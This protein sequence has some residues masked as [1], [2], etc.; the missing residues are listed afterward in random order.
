VL[1]IGFVILLCIFF[2][3]KTEFS[4][5]AIH[6]NKENI[7][8]VITIGN[9][10]YSRDITPFTPAP[11]G[12]ALKD[13][14]PQIKE[15]TN[16]SLIQKELMYTQNYKGVFQRAICDPSFVKIFTFKLLL[17][18]I[19]SFSTSDKRIIFITNHTRLQLFGQD[20]PIGKQ[21]HSGYGHDYTV[22][23]V[24]DD[25]PKESHIQ[26]DAITPMISNFNSWITA[27]NQQT[28]ILLNKNKTFSSSELTHLKH[29][30]KDHMKNYP[31]LKFQPLK[32]I[33]FNNSF[34]DPWIKNK[35]DKR[36]NLLLITATIILVFVMLFNYF[37][38][39]NSLYLS[40]LKEF[41]I[42][43]ILGLTSDKILFEYVFTNSL[44]IIICISTSILTF[45]TISKFWSNTLGFNLGGQLNLIIIISIVFFLVVL[46]PVFLTHLLGRIKISSFSLSSMVNSGINQKSRIV[47]IALQVAI[48]IIIIIFA[49][50]I[51][52]Q[53]IYISRKDIGY[54]YDKIVYLP[55]SQWIYKSELIREILLKDPNIISVCAASELPIDLTFKRKI[56][57][58]DSKTL[59]GHIYAYYAFTD[60]GFLETFNIMLK[61]GTY[62]PEHYSFE[63]YFNDK[64][65][66]LY[67]INEEAV[68]QLDLKDPI[69]KRF[70]CGVL[71]G[72]RII[73]VIKNFHFKPLDRKI[74]P[75]FIQYNPE[76]WQ[77]LFIKL[78]KMDKS[79]FRFIRTT[80][81]K[82]ENN[83]YPI[84]IKYLKDDFKRSYSVVSKMSFSTIV[85]AIV[86]LVLSIIGLIAVISFLGKQKQKT[87][88][89]KKVFGAQD[90]VI[91]KD[92]LFELSIYIIPSIIIS[93]YIGYIGTSKW[94]ETFAY[95]IDFPFMQI[96]IAIAVIFLL[97]VSIASAKVRK[98]LKLNPSEILKYE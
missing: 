29:F 26:F 19:N 83:G 64:K 8:R 70:E 7:Y 11:L 9:S 89:I 66:Q 28:Y 86:A 10:E 21:I 63:Y 39:S 56:T 71:N 73:G 45:Y 95:R 2:F 46:F 59:D 94:L 17:G 72:G 20:D 54:N 35:G 3:L 87:F 49:I 30:L 1:T 58:W 67:L 37:N 55:A 14:F 4:Y 51:T 36:L 80:I 27:Q 77:Y 38:L 81:E 69:N 42:K 53:M 47:G 79:S 43:K 96:T 18:D 88:A 68:K 52:N 25:I 76:N 41:S 22:M 90:L 31:L 85:F 48:S 57:N 65:E 78:K 82:F 44:L 74:E 84:E 62:F 98:S 93:A 24:F 61:E 91:T 34:D 6:T 97:I 16:F 40:K 32:D 92:F 5:E 60:I 50:V 15:A 33:H 12:Q 23:G 75:L 13:E